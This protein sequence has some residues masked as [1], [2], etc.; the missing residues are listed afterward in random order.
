MYDG[1]KSVKTNENIFMKTGIIFVDAGV[2]DGFSMM[3]V[4]IREFM[5]G[6]GTCFHKYDAVDL[7]HLHEVEFLTQFIFEA[8]ILPH[9]GIRGITVCSGKWKLIADF[10][11]FQCWHMFRHLAVPVHP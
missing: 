10:F 5:E 3:Q 8:D 2:K 6:Y 11:A 4:D 1:A 9:D 7:L